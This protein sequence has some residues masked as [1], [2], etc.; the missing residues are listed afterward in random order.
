MR[1]VEFIVQPH[2]VVD[3]ITN[4]STEI[5]VYTGDGALRLIESIVND[6]C[7]AFYYP[8][9][10]IS[11]YEDIAGG[12]F[13][14][15]SGIDPESRVIVVSFDYYPEMPPQMQSLLERILEI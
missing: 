8:Q 7:T 1:K 3:L 6:L 12:Y 14:D 15:D 13:S 2:S 10:N 9:K 4:S 5:F 11:V